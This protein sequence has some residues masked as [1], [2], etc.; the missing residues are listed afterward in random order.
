MQFNLCSQI[1]PDT[2]FKIMHCHE[3]LIKLTRCLFS[4]ICRMNGLHFIVSLLTYVILVHLPTHLALRGQTKF[5]VT[6]SERNFPEKCNGNNMVVA[7]TCT[8]LYSLAGMKYFPIQFT[9]PTLFLNLLFHIYLFPGIVFYK[10]TLIVFS[11]TDSFV[12]GIILNYFL[13]NYR[14]VCRVFRIELLD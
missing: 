14:L 7:L 11:S 10:R 4:K 13:P 9:V 3:K 6:W 1:N 12:F 5:L 2:T 8:K